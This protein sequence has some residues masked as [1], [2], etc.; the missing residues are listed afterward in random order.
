[1]NMKHF[2]YIQLSLTIRLRELLPEMYAL[3]DLGSCSFGHVTQNA[4]GLW[5]HH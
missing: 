1:M 5:R 2:V 4:Y 3:N